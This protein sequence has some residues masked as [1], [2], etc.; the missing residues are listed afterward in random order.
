[1]SAERWQLLKSVFYQALD[2]PAEQ[3]RAWLADACRGDASMLQEVEALLVAHDTAGDFLEQPAAIGPDH[4]DA[5]TLA[6]GTRLGPYEVLHE[7]GR[8][9]MGIVYLAEDHRLGRRVALKALPAAVADDADYRARLRREAR[10]AATISHPAVATI[11]ALEEI[12]GALFIASEYVPGRSLRTEIEHGSLDATRARAIAIDIARALAA[13]HD[14]GVVHRDLKPD[15]VLLT[16]SGGVKVVDFGVAHVQ[17]PEITRLTRAGAMLGTPAYMA[18][19][20]LV[21]GHVDPR[22]DLFAFGIMLS[23]MLTGQHPLQPGAEAGPARTVPFA[24]VIAR[25][26]QADPAARFASA[27]DVLRALDAGAPAVPDDRPERWWW[28]VHQGVVSLI[29]ALLLIAMWGARTAVSGAL[30]R[31]LF[32][33]AAIA[34]TVAAALRL[35]LWF[36]S[37]FYPV[38]LG[39]V[40]RRARHW[41]MAADW[42]FVGTLV[43]AGVLCRDTNVE[44]AALLLGGGIGA[45]VGFLV[46]EPVTT[47]AAFR[48]SAD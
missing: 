27:R 42:L 33:A 18:P 3:R 44:L 7:I 2:Q 45:G 26:M 36:T 11:Y 23:E 47:R 6:P 20:Q 34:V 12:D 32:I 4:D 48:N 29:Y 39:W 16:A 13:A 24:A 38:E 28:E 14:A 41:V 25:C 46:I 22:T 31:T 10:A 21:G 30:G 8:G 15:N 40:R 19:E 37:R 5:V 1:M 35:H 43:A 9:G 17:G